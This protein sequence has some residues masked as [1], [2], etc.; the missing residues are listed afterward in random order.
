MNSL[1]NSYYQGDKDY[2]IRLAETSDLKELLKLEILCWPEDLRSS[3]KDLNRR[4]DIYPQGQFVLELD[5]SVVG[6]IYSQRIQSKGTIE[7]NTAENI[8]LIHDKT[9]PVLQLLAINIHPESQ[10][11]NF[12][13]ELLEFLLQYCAAEKKI[14]EVVGVTLC[15]RY[16]Q[17]NGL[18]FEEYIHTTDELGKIQDPI[19][20]FHERHGAKIE[21]TIPGYRPKDIRNEGNGVLV[22]YDISKRNRDDLKIRKRSFPK[23]NLREIESFIEQIITSCLG[24]EGAAAYSKSRPLM[25][26]GLDS[27][28]LAKLNE[29]IGNEFQLDLEPS[30]FF[31]YNTPS[32]VVAFLQSTLQE[33]STSQNKESETSK[34][35]NTGLDCL[36]KKDSSDL[37][38]QKNTSDK[39]PVRADRSDIAIIGA[40]CSLP[41]GITSIREFW[42][43]LKK[44]ASGI[45]ELP[46]GRFDWPTEIDPLREHQG[47][48]LGGFLEDITSF[49][50]S[51]F[52]ISPNEAESMDPQQRILLELSWKCLE[53]AGYNPEVLSNSKTGVFIGASGSDYNRLLEKTDLPVEAHY[54]T[55][56]SMS[57][58]ANRISYFFNFSGPSIHVDTACS[59]SLVAVHY[60]VQSLHLGECEQVL[61]GGVNLIC[62]PSNTIAYYKAG[63]LSKEGQCKTF[64]K[65]ANGYV[66]AE[67]AVTMMLKP[68][69][70]AI[71][72]KDNIYAVIR[73]TACNHGGQTAGLTVPNPQMQAQLL[74]DAW[75]RAGIKPETLGYLE[76]HGTGTSL[77]DPIEI[78]GIKTAFS[79]ACQPGNNKEKSCGLGSLK[80]NLGHLEATAGIAGLLK[81]A[82]CLRHRELVETINFKE[83]NPKINL[84]KSP[85]Y[86]IKNL[87]K[88][89]SSEHH[90]RRGGVSS[91]GS[92]GTN[93]HV[94]LEEYKSENNKTPLQGPFLFVLSAKD[95]VRL[96]ALVDKYIS[97][98]DTRQGADVSLS[99]MVYTLQTG[100]QALEERLAVICSDKKGLKQK[101]CRYLDNETKIEYL[102]QNNIRRSPTEIN[103]LLDGLS[104]D[105]LIKLSINNNDLENIA[106]F[107]TLGKKID[108]DLFYKQTNPSKISL[109]AYPFAKEQYWIPKTEKNT[110][111]GRVDTP[112]S[113]SQIHPLLHR[114]TSDLSQQ[115][116]SSIFNGTEF[117]LADHQING[118]KILPGVVYLEMARAA[119]E[120]AAVI[121]FDNEESMGIHL[122]N[123]VWVRPITINSDAKEVHVGLFAERN[124]RIQYEIYTESE[125]PEEEYVVHAQGICELRSSNLD[126]TLNLNQIR[127]EM[128]RGIISSDFYYQHI[129]QMGL[130][131]G[132]GHR[133]IED[134]YLGENQVLAKLFLPSLMRNTQNQYVLHPT[135]L[136][137]ALQAAIGLTM[138]IND[139]RSS[140][141]KPSLP[142]ALQDLEISASC[143]ETMYAWVRCV[144]GN[145]PS[146]TVQ[147]LDI[148]LCD[149]NGNICVQMKGYSSRVLE[150]VIESEDKRQDIP[151]K[152]VTPPFVGLNTW[153]PVWSEIPFSEK[154]TMSPSS[155]DRILLIGGTDTQ[156]E[157]VQTI[158]PHATFLSFQPSDSIETIGSELKSTRKGHLFDHI[159]WIAPGSS[160][161][162]PV[163]E[164]VI[165]EQNQ[166]VLQVFR[167]IKALLSLGYG[168]KEIHWTLITRQTQA[169]RKK[170]EVDP[171]HAGIYGLMGSLAKE[172]AHWKIR[173]LDLE[174]EKDWPIQKMFTL[175]A[176]SGSSVLAYREKE[177]LKRKLIP[178]QLPDKALSLYK[179]KG[180]YVVIGG[181]G[182]I[183]EAWSRF[184]I[185]NYQ[186]K[187]VWLG[188]RKIDKEI[189]KKLDSFSKPG[190]KPLYISADATDLGALENAYREIKKTFPRIH[191][192]V[193]SAIVL[194]DQSL[195]NMDEVGFCTGFSAKVDVS[196]R[197][198]QVFKNEPLD[199][200]L[201][202]SSMFSFTTPPGQS[203]YAAGCT[204]KDAF[205]HKLSNSWPCTVKVINWGYW[206]NVGIVTDPFYKDRME[207]AGIGSIETEEGMESLE[208]LVCS[209]ASQ[210]VL[211]KTLEPQALEG[212]DP[213]ERVIFYPH[214][215]PS[216]MHDIQKH[217]P[218]RD[219][220]PELT[221]Q[222]DRHQYKAMEEHLL[223]LLWASL[224]TLG[225]F[226]GTVQTIAALDSGNQVKKYYEHWLK[227]TIRLLLANGFLQVQGENYSPVRAKEKVDLDSL[228]NQWE[229]KKSTWI[230]NPNQKA[231]VL[232]VETC[233]RSLPAILTGKQLA[234]DIMFPN[235]SMELVEGIY[236]DNPVSDFFNGVLGDMLVA[237]IQQRL[238]RDPST[239]IHI[240]E[241]GA[242]TGG[243]T[244]GLLSK[245]RPFVDSIQ[246]YCY[247]DLSK[248]FLLHAE[249]H[250]AP[251]SPYLTTRIF[252]VSKP[253]DE[254]QITPDR[255]DFVIATNVLHATRS[256]RETLRNAK[257]LL[258][259]GGLLL[260]NEISNKSLF[261][262]LTFGLLEGWWLH[263]DF[264]LR[265]DGSPG[266]Y[267]KKWSDVLEE[268]GFLK[269]FFPAKEAHSLGQQVIIAESDGIV[270]QKTIHPPII[271]EKKKTPQVSRQ[272]FTQIKPVIF[273][274]NTSEE[275][276]R[277]KST[278][279][280]KKL[281]G[282][283]LK[284]APHRIDAF[285]PFKEYGIDSILVN[286]LTNNLDKVFD[287]VSSTLFFEVQTIDAL[288]DYFLTTEKE[289]LITLLG[290]STK[291]PREKNL[292]ET[293]IE[294]EPTGKHGFSRK[295][296]RYFSP[297]VLK[298]Q[299][300]KSQNTNVF[301]VA[302][303]GLSGRYPMAKN[304]EEFWKRLKSGTNCITEIPTNRWDW[305]KYYDPEKGKAGKINTRWGGFLE[306]V[307]RFD[308]QFFKISPR[309]A[310]S[311][312]PQERLFLE[313]TYH[314]LQD[315]G[316]TPDN[317]GENR[318]TGVF[319]GVMNFDYGR[320]PDYYT[321][322]NRI[323]Y[324]FDFQGPS[325]AI[326]TACSSSL[327]AIH[328]AMES[329]YSGMSERAIAGGVNLILDSKHYL[330]LSA[331]NMLSSGNKCRSFG[332]KADGF[333]DAEG[334]GAI[335]LKP[336][337]KAI[338]DGDHIY[339]ILK[340][341]ALNA[342]GK[343]NGYT[344]PNPKAQSELV[345]TAFTR[346]GIQPEM[347]SYIEAHSTG[348]TLGD[349]I[350]IAGLTQAFENFSDK[351]QFCAI[352]SV[353]SNI[354][355]C[356]SA[357][358]ISGVTKIL[359]QLKHAQIVPSL[360]SKVLN[361]AIDFSRTPFIVQQELSEWK[362]PVITVN[363]ET[364]EIPRIAGISSFGAG[365][366]NVHVI[367][368]EYIPPKTIQQ[369]PTATISATNPVIIPLS[370]R[371]EADLQQ[372]AKNLLVF[373]KKDTS[374]GSVSHS[375]PNIA[376]LSY[377]LQ[378]GREAMEERLGLIV[379]SPEE[380]VEKLEGYLA[381]K[382]DIEDF[383]FGQVKHNQNTMA[384]FK[385]D[386]DLQKAVET[387]IDKRKYTKL[388]D[389]W[390]K[391][392]DLDWNKLYKDIKLKRISLPTYPFEG[393]RYWTPETEIESG[394]SISSMRGLS[395]EETTDTVEKVS[396]HGTKWS[397]IRP[398]QNNSVT[399]EISL[400]ANEKIEL[401]L[402][403]AVARQL[404]RS[405]VQKK[406][407]FF[408][409][410]LSSFGVVALV[411]ET[412]KILGAELS[413]TLLFEYGSIAELAEYLTQNHVTEIEAIT[414]VKNSMETNQSNASSDQLQ[415]LT[416]N[417]KPI[418]NVE[419]PN[420]NNVD[421]TILEIL[422]NM[423][424]K[425]I[426]P[427]EAKLLIND[428]SN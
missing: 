177:W 44:G 55:G 42:E 22:S 113:V 9:G 400:S 312:D 87:R 199:L 395:S 407:T 422:S 383:Y 92:G 366:A 173:L 110:S 320:Q 102:W 178:T 415:P 17:S 293:F 150:G 318:R 270:R 213:N 32:Q 77:G 319:V 388:L 54:G 278:A 359:L 399:N 5:E 398:G 327:T 118:Q 369:T 307:D 172:Y 342:G 127:S 41:G 209:S 51:F 167:I 188:R 314:A 301:D 61:V 408:E 272:A 201:F 389:L 358:G 332:D 386:E 6:V 295:S 322:A 174:S 394:S 108:W 140:P 255:Y 191:G 346:A 401:F 58:L 403:Q 125:N 344:V 184:M 37:P 277:E 424:N 69:S 276:L 219:L 297:Q 289:S 154:D 43:H 412:E 7:G 159:I 229:V 187:I 20:R 133:G 170:D 341:S 83:L 21:K 126:K 138:D 29:Q 411:K 280:F 26:M 196:L 86:I 145:T 405:E 315:A 4:L 234:T 45:T 257:A 271:P 27:S 414:V 427:E 354:G 67:G 107:W 325:M 356:E 124:N 385:V 416:R 25:E 136:D 189:Q 34:A 226:N 311:M 82:L 343:T 215:L 93:A 3:E 2:T 321:I 103:L 134:I 393:E 117:F 279:F 339:G 375:K 60:A 72:E 183:G 71:S 105:Q 309:E 121:L 123:V 406:A 160:L 243:T 263:E 28:D 281:I 81:V 149:E 94:V 264:A 38:E 80:S 24:K 76:A 179:S 39:N 73:G 8:H 265:I 244:A 97:W 227:E 298:Q 65:E 372:V 283:T 135:L 181:A 303:V 70:K 418:N 329:L 142:Y 331:L 288:V 235:S 18:P 249:Q 50:A 203:N 214:V 349:A 340:G 260:L 66:R 247:T 230:Q 290:L 131:Y 256:I 302:I 364:R 362:R 75:S 158:Y 35:E 273:L 334:V 33:E 40:S 190:S 114:N 84:E 1:L 59:S 378:V 204:F 78:Q 371:T 141:L 200:L 404:Q 291:A 376:D 410:G 326:D 292:P 143:M 152:S 163:D 390:V 195:A 317:F 254:Q 374:A 112:F 98:L 211:I 420:K 57:V 155:D 212:T 333:V 245:L 238:N 210:A 166:G 111:S 79:K 74:L 186:A 53:D 144:E 128:N 171:T 95:E 253:L 206:G 233:L 157:R 23:K 258:H 391:G 396:S 300:L 223:K 423:E 373:I 338:E 62:H 99:D 248:A 168:K 252:D 63:M 217:L 15:K 31:E 175:P 10:D 221:T 225:F 164:T 224:G 104:G 250:Y 304:L 294:P 330:R 316:Y 285:K 306:D 165:Q 296:G 49:D 120:Q 345:S 367:I 182:G 237:A 282:E 365:G 286:Q 130:E 251:G 30:F 137:S 308:P 328:L 269:I 361:P 313:T 148:D 100:R 185:K 242:G 370:A 220:K 208:N 89:T 397:F 52:R 379:G 176:N 85:F 310:E 197:L 153:I 287:N 363:G 14:Q 413:P 36:K 419:Y 228:W 387:W 417:S 299:P 56:C 275:L 11:R 324:L 335:V 207:K 91:F 119:V 169:V 147:K 351:K 381:G 47:I 402:Q 240:L 106:I 19:L 261:N 259:S 162:S 218:K 377:T 129:R 357:A 236:K 347:L 239:K 284:M 360:H 146:D 231:Q 193:H 421:P 132:P 337:H 156:K 348:T 202:F 48:N 305:Q 192:V 161:T 216:V 426:S 194:H 384:V 428:I 353:K 205:A 122:K 151:S 425:T 139:T 116:Y 115:R 246:E 12:G 232:L 241:I 96:R 409:L 355:H 274:Q 266:L 382:D 68:L 323:S 101:L 262:H 392:F 198:A 109:P 268:E 380:L 267:P 180:V 16:E 13:D 88:W 222:Q 336:L 350:E 46:E 352:G 368:E 90:L 64:D